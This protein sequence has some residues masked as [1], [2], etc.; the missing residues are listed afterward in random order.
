MEITD[1]FGDLEEEHFRQGSSMCK[2]SEVGIG[3]MMLRNRE[4]ANV[5]YNMSFAW[6]VQ[7]DILILSISPK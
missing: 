7:D 6:V 1:P 5:S 2:E 4:E 3:F